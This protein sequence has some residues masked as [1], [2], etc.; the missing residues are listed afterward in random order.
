MRIALIN[1]F[2]PPD[3]A[4]TG[5]MAASLAEHRAKSGDLIT[6]ITSVGGYVPE[7]MAD[8]SSSQSNPRVIRLWTPRLGKSRKLTR[9]LDYATF[10]LLATLRMIL[11]P[12]QDMVISLTTPPFIAWTAIFHK[13]LHPDT[14]ILLWN[15]DCYPEIAERTGVIQEGRLISRF[16]RALNRGLFRRVDGVVCLDTAM[17]ALLQDHYGHVDPAP[18]FHIIPNWEPLSQFPLDLVPAPWVDAPSYE[19][20]NPFVILYLGNAGFGHRFETVIEVAERLK[21][22]PFVFLFVGG[23]QKWSWL[24][25]AARSRELTNIILRPY[26]PKETT[27]SVMVLAHCALITMSEKALG[28]I[29]PSKLHANL[30]MR[31]PILYIG[32]KGSNVD[33]ALDEFGFGLSVRHGETEKVIAFLRDLYHDPDRQSRL[34]QAARLAFEAAFCD[35][36][37]LPQFDQLLSSLTA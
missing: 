9:I 26:V 12:R 14:K 25:D 2:F 18:R 11:L 22:E 1:Q 19:I 13:W 23:G 34:Q 3:L 35:T 28:L 29:S 36:R 27:P 17:G 16:L 6:V 33:T 20:D 8:G 10:Y 37:T 30:A 7:S 4:P 21:D 24:A 15:M 5:H 32:P 31:L